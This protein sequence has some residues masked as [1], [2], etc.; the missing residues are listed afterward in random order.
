MSRSLKLPIVQQRCRNYKISSWYWRPIRRTWKHV[1][2][3]FHWEYSEDTGYE[4]NDTLPNQKSLIN[5]YDYSD[6]RFSFVDRYKQWRS[7]DRSNK[8]CRK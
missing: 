3:T 4:I 1:I 8:F 6:Y 2:N 7:K 5:D